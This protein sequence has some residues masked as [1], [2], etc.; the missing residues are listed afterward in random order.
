M[1]EPRE[2]VDLNSGKT[3]Y[4]YQDGQTVPVQKAEEQPAPEAGEQP[5]RLRRGVSAARE[6]ARRVGDLFTPETEGEGF[7]KRNIGRMGIMRSFDRMFGSGR[8]AQGTIGQLEPIFKDHMA[9][10]QAAIDL[11]NDRQRREMERGQNVGDIHAETTAQAAANLTALQESGLEEQELQRGLDRE[12]DSQDRRQEARDAWENWEAYGGNLE[13]AMHELARVQN[14]LDTV[15]GQQAALD[16]FRR[17]GREEQRLRRYQERIDNGLDIGAELAAELAAF[18]ESGRNLLDQRAA[19]ARMAAREDTLYAD[20]AAIEAWRETGQYLSREMNEQDVANALHRLEN[21]TAKE[22][23]IMRQNLVET[24]NLM[25]IAENENL[26]NKYVMLDKA[27]R[28]ARAAGNNNL[29]AA[30]QN[31]M[32]VGV[33]SRAGMGIFGPR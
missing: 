1:A 4:G 6:G 30:I 23:E 32:D 18:E 28:E 5:G 21:L 15:E 25:G 22:L 19:Q 17:F 9:N 3:H 33:V 7:H 12:Q 16:A 20:Q 13:E 10:V 11:E 2:Y 29:A 26:V 24:A 14:N 8:S 31:H 27:V